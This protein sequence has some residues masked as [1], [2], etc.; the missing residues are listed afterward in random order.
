[1]IET[2]NTAINLAYLPCTLKKCESVKMQEENIFKE[3]KAGKARDIFRKFSK[4][5]LKKQAL[6]QW[7]GQMNLWKPL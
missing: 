3:E 1:M 2:L 5:S 4:T 6:T 7:T